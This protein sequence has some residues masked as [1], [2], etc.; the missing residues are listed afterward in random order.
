MAKAGP[1]LVAIHTVINRDV[2][3]AVM[4]AALQV[5]TNNVEK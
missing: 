1:A 2:V 4:M 5:P 3:Q